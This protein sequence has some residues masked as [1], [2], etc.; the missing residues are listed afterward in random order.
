MFACLQRSVSSA[1][2]AAVS[3]RYRVLLIMIGAQICAAVV[4]QGFGSLAPFVVSFLHITK[5][6][7][8]LAVAALMIGSALT[9]GAGGIAVDRFGERTV[10]VAAGIGI[11]ITLMLAAAVPSYTWLVFWLF[12][13]GATY[14]GCSPAGG[15]AVLSWFERDRGFAMSLRQTGVPAGAMIGG[16]ILPPLALHADY[17]LALF[18][19]G[20]IALFGTAGLALLYR[21]PKDARSRRKSS[22]GSMLDG[23]RLFVRDR[24]A[25]LVTITGGALNGAQQISAGF[26]A[27]SAIVL[28]HFSVQLAAL[29]FSTTMGF[30][31]LGRIGWGWA[32]DNLFRGDRALPLALTCGLGALGGVGIAMLRPGNTTLLFACA[33]LFGLGSTGWNG[34]YATL[35]AELG[36]VRHAGSAL[37]VGYTVNFAIGAVAPIGFGAVGDA[38]GLGTAWMAYACALALAA[39]PSLLARQ[40]A[41]AQPHAAG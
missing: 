13:V 28:G 27:L 36:G 26:V 34:L 41:A 14:S 12:M 5:A 4:E 10:T 31:I 32:S 19:G 38:F 9:V 2:L 17:R 22:P 29:S 8:G 1:C 37:G 25:L 24:R 16:L 39:I 33:I 18:C 30:A 11:G 7:L 3:M 6:Q 35:L 21:E 23:V 20:L 15:R 40:F